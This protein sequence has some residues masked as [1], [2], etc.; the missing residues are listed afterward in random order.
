MLFQKYNIKDILIRKKVYEEW[1]EDFIIPIEVAGENFKVKYMDAC[2][3]NNKICATYNT[4]KLYEN[5][6]SLYN[7]KL[8]TQILCFSS[9]F[10]FI[11][12]K[13]FQ[14]CR[15]FLFFIV[16]VFVTLCI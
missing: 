6:T 15:S 5:Y 3:I 2:N 1:L 4:Y 16:A 7:Y 9:G 13:L 14:H 10:L 8:Y 12:K 11:I